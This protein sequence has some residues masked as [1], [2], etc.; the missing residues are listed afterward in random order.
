MD[1]QASIERLAYCRGIEAE[2]RR[3]I[4]ELEAELAET[5]AGRRLTK[6]RELL[7]IAKADRASA[8]ETV[9]K[10]ALEEFIQSGD[11]QPHEATTIKMY[12]VLDYNVGNAFEYCR[13]H[14][15]QA[16]KL[17]VRT[18]EKFAK[19]VPP[20]FVTVTKVPRVTIA[21]A[22]EKYRVA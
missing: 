16:V 17:D 3:E 18:F 2:Y 15:P 20:D 13:Q 11:K 21:R 4:A 12:T 5:P 22:L 10:A 19:V 14:L 9:R 8:E 7:D 6:A 1:L